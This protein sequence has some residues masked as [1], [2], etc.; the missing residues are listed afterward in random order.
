MYLGVGEVVDLSPLSNLDK[1]KY[2]R[3]SNWNGSLS[4]LS[5]M[6]QLESLS[7]AWGTVPSIAP[8]AQLTSLRGLKLSGVSVADYSPLYGLPSLGY[9]DIRFS[10]A[11]PA[12]IS[13]L[14]AQLPGAQIDY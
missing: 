10:G 11:T 12:Q 9:V 14:Q 3:L 1:V 7:I 2:R 13:A 8:L 4:Y 6:V 5:N